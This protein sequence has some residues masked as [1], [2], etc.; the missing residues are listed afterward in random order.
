SLHNVLKEQAKL[1]CLPENIGRAKIRNLFLKHA[2]HDYLLFLDCD[3]LIEKKDFLATYLKLIKKENPMITCGG[4][5][6]PT[7]PPSVERMLRWKYGVA[8]ESKPALDRAENPHRSFMTNNFLANRSLF[9]QIRF[10][11]TLTQYGHEDTLFGFEI[12]K[13][14]I[15]IVHI[16]NPVLNGDLETNEEFLA[17]TDLGVQNLVRIVQSLES[18]E[19][20]IQDVNLLNFYSEAVEKGRIKNFKRVDSVFG[21]RIL[22]KLKNGS[23]SVK[24]FSF[25]KLMLLVRYLEDK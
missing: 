11:E 6:Y 12:K 24:Q 16:E 18:P 5:V 3:S 17:K 14:K 7:N 19:Q 8:S 10:D 21:K 15:P 1:I 20:F 23:G 13:L 4:R 25:Y 9:D 2:R 22:R